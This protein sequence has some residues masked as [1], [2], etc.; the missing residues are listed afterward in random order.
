MKKYLLSFFFV[1]FFFS[2]VSPAFAAITGLNDIA[3]ALLFGSRRDGDSEDN[4]YNKDADAICRSQ[5]DGWFR[6]KPDP[7]LSCKSQTV[8]IKIKKQ[9]EDGNETTS[10]GT[11]KANCYYDCIC[12]TSKFPYLKSDVDSNEYFSVADDANTCTFN[13]ETRVSDIICNSETAGSKSAITLL[14]DA[15]ADD[16]IQVLSGN[17]KSKTCYAY[18]KLECRSNH[19]K[20]PNNADVAAVVQLGSNYQYTVFIKGD[21][22]AYMVAFSHGLDKTYAEFKDKSNLLG[23][24]YNAGN[25]GYFYNNNGQ[26]K[27]IGSAIKT[28]QP[29]D[30]CANYT[31]KAAQYFPS[32]T[33]YYHNG[34][35]KNDENCMEAGD[36]T[37]C[38]NIATTSGD[39][40]DDKN[41]EKI[42]FS[43]PYNSGYIKGLRDT[44][45][46]YCLDPDNYNSGN[47][48]GFSWTT[49]GIDEPEVIKVTGC[50]TADGYELYH[51]GP[52][53]GLYTDVFNVHNVA[54]TDSTHIYEVSSVMTLM[55]DGDGENGCASGDTCYE[56]MTCRKKVGCKLPAYGT[57]ICHKDTAW[58]SWQKSNS[59]A[60]GDDLCVAL[61]TCEELGYRMTE[62][63][64]SQFGFD[65][66]RCPYDYNKVFCSIYG[67]PD[68]CEVGSFYNHIT[69][70]CGIEG[71]GDYY[72]VAV[73]DTTYGKILET[74]AYNQ[75]G[76]VL[77][78]D[79]CSDGSNVSVTCRNFAEMQASAREKCSAEG[80]DDDLLNINQLQMV[81]DTFGYYP[82]QSDPDFAGSSAETDWIASNGELFTHGGSSSGHLSNKG[83]ICKKTFPAQLY[84]NDVC[85]IKGMEA[86]IPNGQ[87]CDTVLTSEGVTCYNNCRALTCSDYEGY[88]T[89][90]PS[91]YRCV[92]EKL[93]GT[94]TYC[95]SNC[96]INTCEANGYYSVAQFGEICESI[97]PASTSLSC[98]D[99]T[100]ICDAGMYYDGISQFCTKDYEKGSTKYYVVSATKLT[101]Q[102][103]LTVIDIEGAQYV[104]AET[105]RNNKIHSGTMATIYSGC[106]GADYLPSQYE[107]LRAFSHNS[108]YKET[109]CYLTSED[110]IL[111]GTTRY[112][113][114]D[115]PPGFGTCP[116]QGDTTV[117]QLNA[118]CRETKTIYLAVCD[119]DETFK[120]N[121][122]YKGCQAGQ[123]Y[124]EGTDI[125]TDTPEEHFMV[126]V[127]DNCF[128]AYIITY[129][130]SPDFG[131][132][133]TIP[134][135]LYN[136][137]YLSECK[138][139]IGCL[140][141]M[142]Q[143]S[144][145]ANKLGTK[146]MV[147]RDNNNK[148]GI[149][150]DG[151]FVPYD[152]FKN[153]TLG[154]KGDD[155]TEL[156]PCINDTG[157]NYT[158][159]IISMKYKD[160]CI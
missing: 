24:V 20:L 153:H 85:V 104:S 21:P 51:N 90:E 147:V 16:A 50:N 19:Y 39:A 47:L 17:G 112:G 3:Y 83:V 125:C 89:E 54:G 30:S 78:T 36:D 130:A 38:I 157:D 123:Y 144:T 117:E 103:K 109:N 34:T 136:A 7:N 46:N 12:D 23:C 37:S 160:K 92:R 116:K 40:F 95:Y 61:P 69:N 60:G 129:Q 141:T 67:I 154:D 29:A 22:I 43:C 58:G 75:R 14:F 133:D 5:G 8:T 151:T 155:L 122:C 64:C 31:T 159:N 42:R 11:A 35:C 102:F 65:L 86:V 94:E 88:Y 108:K 52:N 72:V 100:P 81:Y 152:D 131:T 126:E 48:S 111:R 115:N 77:K 84:S 44:H 110:Y 140:P 138:K 80:F 76:F 142:D 120:N 27:V 91:G 73:H 10:D 96:E 128:Y 107:Y 106:Y 56:Y 82:L 15:T 41:G 139:D 145:I 150:A 93:S 134:L 63:Q 114:T 49:I 97:T 118:W 1:S 101:K 99:C 9:G 105:A 70:T 66:I 28:T 32:L 6:V 79:E 13:G 146:C 33:Y 149:Y 113:T 71:H 2:C 119:E 4:L 124:D 25:A 98:Y 137:A 148:G 87:T 18:D 45:G 55:T 26:R 156:S 59:S 143:A 57:P 62:A 127:T 121:Q 74:A 158:V 132:S 68:D 135:I 53:N